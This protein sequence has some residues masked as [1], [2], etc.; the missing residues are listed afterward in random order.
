MEFDPED[1]NWKG[2]LDV[3]S[4]GSQSIQIMFSYTGLTSARLE[5]D[6]Q[7]EVV[8]SCTTDVISLSTEVPAD[9]LES[10]EE[11]EYEANEEG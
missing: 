9:L 1:S 3:S 5:A 8:M 4:S 10:V 7:I 2:Q 11:V 6:L